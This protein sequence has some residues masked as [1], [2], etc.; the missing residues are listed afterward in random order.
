MPGNKKLA[1]AAALASSV[2][3]AHGSTIATGFGEGYFLH[4]LDVKHP[5]EWAGTG[6]KVLSLATGSSCVTTTNLQTVTY[7]YDFYEEQKDFASSLGITTDTSVSGS[8]LMFSASGTVSTAFSSSS[9]SS[10]SLSSASLRQKNIVSHSVVDSSCFSTAASFTD[11]FNAAFAA[12]PTNLEFGTTGWKAVAVA[13]DGSVWEQYE[14]FIHKWGSHVITGVHFG[15]AA[16]VL[17]V[18][19]SEA[20][21]DETDFKTTA[22]VQ[23]SAMGITASECVGYD[24]SSSSSSSSGSLSSHAYFYG[25]DSKLGVDAQVRST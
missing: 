4:D 7:D 12:L 25:G 13:T 16:E 6:A 20:E 2:A 5:F 22:C 19:T 9:S 10:S 18:A 3:T 11:E 23:G 8:A 15:A 21:T 14:D 1:A 17:V 24:K